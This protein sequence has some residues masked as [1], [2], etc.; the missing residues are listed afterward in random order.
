MVERDEI[1][2]NRSPAWNS[3]LEDLPSHYQGENVENIRQIMLW[4]AVQ[5]KR[6]FSQQ[7]GFYC[8]KQLAQERIEIEMQDIIK[9]QDRE[10]LKDYF[11]NGE[12]VSTRMAVVMNPLCDPNWL[13]GDVGMMYFYYI[14]HGKQR[15]PEG[16]HNNMLMMSVEGDEKSNKYMDEHG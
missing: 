8:D 14:K 16:L 3:F 1:N 5:G 13:I 2:F 11:F 15:L 10:A 7:F 4:R 6:S 12:D 9:S